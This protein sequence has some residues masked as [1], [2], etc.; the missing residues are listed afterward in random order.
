MS[1][2]D[3]NHIIIAKNIKMQHQKNCSKNCI[4]IAKTCRLLANALCMEKWGI[5]ITKYF[6]NKITFYQKKYS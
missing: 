1:K 5:K 4:L 6:L 2:Y 3:K